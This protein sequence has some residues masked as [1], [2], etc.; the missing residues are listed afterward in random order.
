M[1]TNYRGTQ[2]RASI[3]AYF[4]K[5]KRRVPLVSTAHDRDRREYF[6]AHQFSLNAVHHF[7]RKITERNA[8][9]RIIK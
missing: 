9:G 2:C 1:E 4:Y 8:S 5:N 7:H 3:W 6:I